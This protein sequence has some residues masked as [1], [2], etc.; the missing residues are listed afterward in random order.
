MYSTDFYCDLQYC[1]SQRANSW[2]SSSCTNKY[3]QEVIELQRRNKLCKPDPNRDP[4]FH[5]RIDLWPHIHKELYPD[6][7]IP[8][9]PKHIALAEKDSVYQS[10]KP[11]SPDPYFHIRKYTDPELHKELYPD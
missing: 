6:I 4:Y 2:D 5:I 1:L 9:Q 11:K 7:P 3:E 8:P 10:T